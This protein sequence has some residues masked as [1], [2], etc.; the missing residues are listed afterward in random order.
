[1]KIRIDSVQ[2][3]VADY[4]LQTGIIAEPAITARGNGHIVVIYNSTE[5]RTFKW[6]RVNA[7]SEWMGSELL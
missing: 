4:E 2:G 6:V 7:N 5:G 3:V 1:M